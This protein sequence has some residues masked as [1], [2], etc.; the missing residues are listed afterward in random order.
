MRNFNS[1]SPDHA[2]PVTS[3][4]AAQ[5]PIYLEH[6]IN[7]HSLK[8]PKIHFPFV[9]VTHAKFSASFPAPKKFTQKFKKS[10]KIHIQTDFP[11]SKFHPFLK[12]QQKN[13][14]MRAKFMQ[15]GLFLFLSVSCRKNCIIFGCA[16]M[17]FC[18][19]DEVLRVFFVGDF[20]G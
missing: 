15:I 8:L 7:I 17:C 18:F 19:V 5:K 2:H 20:I 10:P 13:I 6:F 11:M 9:N 16:D 1:Q 12:Q 3:F 4:F 14:C